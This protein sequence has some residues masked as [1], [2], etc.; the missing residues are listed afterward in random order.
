M[1]VV[2]ASLVLLLGLALGGASSNNNSKLLA[3]LN[4]SAPALDLLLHIDVLAGE[5]APLSTAVGPLDLESVIRAE[6][7]GDWERAR[8]VLQLAS[9]ARTP[10]LKH[11]I[12]EALWQELQQTKQ[13]YDPLKLL[14]FHGQLTALSAVPPPLLAN[15]YQTFV[16]RSAQLLAAPFH[17]ASHSANF[18]LVSALLQR[19]TL[20]TLDYLRDILEALFDLVLALESTLSVVQRWGNLSASLTQLTLANLQ[21][22]KRPELQLDAAART[23][24]QANLRQLLEQP[25]FEPDVDG[26]L[27]QQLYAQLPKDERILYTAQKVCLRNMTDGNAYIYECPQTYLICTNARDPKKA[28]YYVQRGH[29]GPNNTLQFAFYSA[30]WRNRYILLEPSNHSA[31]GQQHITKNVYSRAAIDWWH[32]VQ[33]AGGGVAIYDAA[34]TR[35]VLCGG[36]PQHWDGEEKHVYTRN[37]QEFA[38]NRRECAWSI[39]DCSDVS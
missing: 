37:A 30:Y 36:N 27:R 12:Y 33:L 22:L 4:G 20:S 26:T 16:G 38:T 24:L 1:T 18:P 19:L 25:A 32:V 31:T 17:T 23:A 6:V 3:I 34:T 39:E 29:G 35:S 21:L 2:A 9:Q 11:A 15:V 10:E 7:N 8:L 13:I 14:E 28:A 5:M